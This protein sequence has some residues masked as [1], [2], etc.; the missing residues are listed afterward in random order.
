MSNVFEAILGPHTGPLWAGAAALVLK[1]A[2]IW[3]ER[4]SGKRDDF[5]EVNSAHANLNKSLQSAFTEMRLELSRLREDAQ[6]E[7]ER[8]EARIAELE[9]ELEV[10]RERARAAG[11]TLE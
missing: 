2:D 6:R 3:K 9:G 8:Y 10:L 4:R 1:G 7:R 5:K 11:I